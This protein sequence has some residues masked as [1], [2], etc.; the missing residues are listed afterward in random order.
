MSSNLFTYKLG[1][2][3]WY[4]A[5]YINESDIAVIVDT[6]RNT[7]WF[8]EGS[9]S[10]SRDRSNARELLVELKNNYKLYEF[11]WISDIAPIEI[12]EELERFKEMSY[13]KGFLGVR[14]N[15]TK[16][17]KLYVYLNFLGA[18]LVIVNFVFLAEIVF[19]SGTII[20]NGYPHYSFDLNTFNFS[21]Y[22]VSILM[23]ASFLI[24]INSALM[25]LLLKKK[26]SFIYS[27]IASIFVF[28]AFFILRIWNVIIFYEE[29]SFII[30][31][32]KDLLILLIFNLQ[33]L[34]IIS[35]ILGCFTGLIG[36]N[37]KKEIEYLQDLK[38]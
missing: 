4:K 31:I 13:L 12:L 29:I 18:F 26:K 7:I 30:Y 20:Y 19:S 8:F 6:I 11:K 23:L 1:K 32:R 10:T 25:V 15:L 9:K 21:I 27:F 5:D 36:I 2:G 16:F 28:V 33:L 3:Q 24:F 35:V 17:S 37:L 38:E 22:F 14:Y 34:Q